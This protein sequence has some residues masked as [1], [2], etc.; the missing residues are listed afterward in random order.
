MKMGDRVEMK[1][2]EDMEME[3]EYEYGKWKPESGKGKW[4]ME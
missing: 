3:I 1:M 4:G 2:I